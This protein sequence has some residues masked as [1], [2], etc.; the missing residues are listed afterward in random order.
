VNSVRRMGWLS[1]VPFKPATKRALA[2]R[3]Y[4]DGISNPKITEDHGHSQGAAGEE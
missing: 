4:L 2:V 1:G 3:M